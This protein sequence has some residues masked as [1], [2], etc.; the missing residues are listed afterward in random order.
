M[1]RIINEFSVSWTVDRKPECSS[2]WMQWSP[3]MFHVCFYFRWKREDGVRSHNRGCINCEC[4]ERI[5][6][7]INPYFLLGTNIIF[8]FLT[9][10][11]GYKL[12][13]LLW[14]Q[15]LG[16]EW[17]SQAAFGRTTQ[18]RELQRAAESCREQGL[19]PSHNIWPLFFLQVLLWI[20][21]ADKSVLKLQHWSSTA[22]CPVLSQKTIFFICGL[23]KCADILW[24]YTDH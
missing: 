19:G 14:Y 24:L 11:L 21:N 8:H 6:K 5:Q 7:F 10:S 12:S 17:Y 20:F 22:F 3:L 16:C 23:L 9:I 2:A 4:N 15:P 1:S 18:C 13:S